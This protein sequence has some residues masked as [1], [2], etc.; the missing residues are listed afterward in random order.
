MLI[1]PYN[2]EYVANF[3]KIKQQLKDSLVGLCVAIEHVGSTAI[4]DLAAKPIIDIDIIYNEKS[5]FEHIKKS[6]ETIGYYYNGDQGITGRDVF[7][8]TVGHYN[9]ILDNVAHHLYVCKYDCNELHRHLLFR[10]YLRKNEDARMYYQQLKYEIAAEANQD[11]KVYAN[12]KELKSNSFINY[13][14]TLSKSVHQ[15]FDKVKCK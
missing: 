3:N 5:D 10:D 12:L 9:I 11:R 8:R 2:S 7:K 14:I 15:G 6:L 4:P 1:A 13:V